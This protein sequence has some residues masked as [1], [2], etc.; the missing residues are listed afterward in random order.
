MDGTIALRNDHEL[1]RWKL[2]VLEA[3]LQKTPA[4]LPA[5]RQECHSLIRILD[6]HLAREERVLTPCEHRLQPSVC[7]RLFGEHAREQTLLREFDAVFT[8]GSKLPTGVVVERLGALV[9]AL[10]EHFDLEERDVFSAVDQAA[11][12]RGAVKSHTPG[13]PS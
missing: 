1:L 4:A 3:D 8:A 5:L 11:H 7:A 12:R 6:Q 9:G 10:R 2:D 13:G